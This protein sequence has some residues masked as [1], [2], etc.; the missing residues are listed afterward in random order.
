MVRRILTEAEATALFSE[1]KTSWAWSGCYFHPLHSTSRKEVLAFD[2]EPLEGFFPEEAFRLFLAENGISTVL[3]HR[4]LDPSEEI[5]VSDLP[6][7]YGLSES[8]IVDQAL[9]WIIYW[10]H[11]G[12]VTFGGRRLIAALIT[13]LPNWREAECKW[14]E[15]NVF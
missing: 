1:V 2:E 4:E 11:E 13:R 3:W 6:Q 9:E 12:T 8:F 7:L 15:A 5:L 10:S 14:G